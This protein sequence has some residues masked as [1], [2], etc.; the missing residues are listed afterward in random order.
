MRREHTIWNLSKLN[1]IPLPIFLRISARRNNNIN[2]KSSF[3][4]DLPF[5]EPP[6]CTRKQNIRQIS[7]FVEQQH[8]KLC[9]R[10][11]ESAIVLEDFR[12]IGCVHDACE[13][14]AG[15]CDACSDQLST[16]VLQRKVEHT[17]SL[18][19]L[20]SRLQYLLLNLLH[21]I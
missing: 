14:H 16:W 21:H 10:I 7:R 3:N 4:P 20:K 5:A 15:V 17:F 2:G 8:D 18:K 11:P 12:A 1:Y 9:L 6:L 19:P 13:E